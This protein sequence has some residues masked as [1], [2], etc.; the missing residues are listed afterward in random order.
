MSIATTETSSTNTSSEL[1]AVTKITSSLS[2]YIV[3]A[4]GLFGISGFIF[5]ID[6]DSKIT[7]QN[8]ITDNFI[9][10]NSVLNDHIATLPQSVTLTR[11]VGELV[12][13]TG[14]DEAKTQ[15][16][17]L[18]TNLAPI[19][20]FLPV[21]VSSGKNAISDLADGNPVDT[22]ALSSVDNL[23]SLFQNLN[24]SA[25]AQ[26]KAYIYFKALSDERVLVSLQTPFG[27]YRNM[28]IE[29]IIATQGEDSQDISEFQITLKQVRFASITT[30]PFNPDK[31]QSRAKNQNAPK[32]KNGKASGQK[33]NKSLAA[34]LLL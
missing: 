17:A 3:R 29:T 18:A 33:K 13:R 28:A 10:D 32:T 1:D 15:A 8:N 7:L 25:T 11:Y 6:G 34:S 21:L 19:A 31:F 24:P 2:S 16:A 27:Y 22:E 30:V 4:S 14:E 20:A 5:D 26:Q 12:N 23:Y 9:E